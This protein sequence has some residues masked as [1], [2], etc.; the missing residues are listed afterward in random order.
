[1]SATA[2]VAARLERLESAAQIRELAHRYAL[3]LDSRDIDMLVGLY[4]DDVW[5]TRDRSGRA[6]MREVVSDT[7]MR[8]VGLTI[9]HVGNHVIDFDGPDHAHGVVYCRGEVQTD[10]DTFI[11]QAIHY[12]DTYARRDGRWYFTRRKHIL[13]Y[14][15]EFGR[16]PVDLPPANWPEHHTGKGLLPEM[17][18]SWQDFWGP[19]QTD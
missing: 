4:V 6:A 8:E 5:V 3:A 11:S 16:R 18:P 1:M 12:G 19:V 17:W 9:L 14:G 13:F 2:D 15:V 7:V 10:E